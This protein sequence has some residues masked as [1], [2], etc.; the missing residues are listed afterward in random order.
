MNNITSFWDQ[1][2]GGLPDVVIALLVLVLALALA[3]LAKYLTVKL[4]GLAGM[5]KGM[6]KTG[7]EDEKIEKTANFFGQLAYLIVFAL[8]L[9]GIFEKLGLNN[10]AAPIVAMMNGFMA[11]LPKII[12]A[13]L[14]AVVGL[15]IGKLVA[16]LL[17]PVLAK[18]KLNGQ[19]AKTGIDTE[20]IDVADILVKIVRTVIVVFFVVEALNVLQLEVLTH[21]GAQIIAYLPYALSAT[22][23]LLLAYLLGSWAEKSLVKNLK[24]SKAAA[25]AA[26][27]A[28]VVLGVFMSLYQ[29]GIASEMV[30]AAFIIVLGAVGVAF[31]VAFG[32]GGRDFAAHTMNKLEKKLNDTTKK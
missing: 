23:V 7:V 14:I 32:I 12:G 29:L 15:F 16:E 19:V 30:N 13:I 27:V 4:L 24:A 6:S 20:K 31:A 26:K 8:F 10:V 17:T 5:Q 28:I 2:L 22:I 11:Y 18:T 25:F 1:F 9:P 3:S 21:I